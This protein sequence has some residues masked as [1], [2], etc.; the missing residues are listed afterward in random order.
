M[1][2]FVTEL[3]PVTPI[4]PSPQNYAL[5]VNRVI[6]ALIDVGISFVVAIVLYFVMGGL[7]TGMLGILGSVSGPGK[8]GSDGLVAGLGCF[9][10]LS[11]LFLPA[12]A[13]FAFGL[14]NKVYLVGTR[15]ASIGQGQQKLRVVKLNGTI[16]P[17]PTL[18]LRLLVQTVFI[19][20]P[21]L[22]I[23]DLLWPL[24][25]EKRQTLHDKAVDTYVI[26]LP[27]S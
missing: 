8:S 14:Y 20:V 11:V 23:L 12:L 16:V 15:G 21:F 19:F 2:G 9:G 6:A 4:V 17:V 18:V 25:D 10:C 26:S 7:F 13:N 22:P 5:W 24:W 1:G 27:Y 3:T